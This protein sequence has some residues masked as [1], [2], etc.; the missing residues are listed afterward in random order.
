MRKLRFALACAIILIAGKATPADLP[1]GLDASA[2]GYLAA[3]VCGPFDEAP[4]WL[5]KA[6]DGK[7]VVPSGHAGHALIFW[8]ES[9]G[10]ICERVAWASEADY[11]AA[12]AYMNLKIERHQHKELPR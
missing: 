12:V 10:S 5:I 7:H 2:F 4:A 9:D 3:K 11:L 1:P 6:A 8:R